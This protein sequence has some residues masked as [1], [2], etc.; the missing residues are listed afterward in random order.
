MAMVKLPEGTQNNSYG[1]GVS[2]L[3]DHLPAC[4]GGFTH[5][6]TI[7]GNRKG[8]LTA[9]GGDANR[10]WNYDLS[11]DQWSGLRD[12]LQE[13][14]LHVF[15]IKDKGC[16]CN[17]VHHP[18]LWYEKRTRKKDEKRGCQMGKSVEVA[19]DIEGGRRTITGTPRS[20]RHGNGSK[21]Q[22]CS[23]L[24]YLFNNS[25][26]N[27]S[28]PHKILWAPWC[29]NFTSM[30]GWWFQPLWKILVNGKDYPIYIMENIMFET[31]N[32]M[33]LTISN[34]SHRSSKSHQS[35][36]TVASP[37]LAED[38]LKHERQCLRGMSASN[39]VWLV[40]ST[41]LKNIS[42]LGW[43]FPIYP[44]K[45]FQTTNKMCVCVWCFFGKNRE[46]P[47]EFL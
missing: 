35:Q 39:H 37:Q 33:S 9:G 30:S 41:L 6:I 11:Y 15:T 26:V 13:T 2:P 7:Q 27:H 25:W 47:M 38:W 31:T 18:V 16:S 29:S 23:S 34:S 12:N 36:S 10:S 44:K 28:Q 32:Q 43:F 14:V 42:Q 45:M 22:R 8:D 17:F 4:T 1:H 21:T 20:H 19:N 40:V 5:Q 46:R 3:R 24:W